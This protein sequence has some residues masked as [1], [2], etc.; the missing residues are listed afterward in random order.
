MVRV[1]TANSRVQGIAAAVKGM[2]CRHKVTRADF[3]GSDC[4]PLHHMA[5]RAAVG[6]IGLGTMGGP[7]A[8]TLLRAGYPLVVYDLDG[9]ATRRLASAGARP[10]ANVAEVARG[11]RTVILMLPSSPEVRQVMEGSEGLLATLK[12]GSL[13]VDMSTIDPL[14]TRQLA[15]AAAERGI[16]MLDAPVSGGPPAAEKGSLTIMVGGEEG[17]FKVARPLFEELGSKVVRCGS[18]GMG[19]TVKLVNQLMAGINMVGVAEALNLGVRCGVDPRV[20][21]EV[22]H[23]ATGDSRVLATRPPY[24]GLVARAPVEE[25]Y[26]GGFRTDLLRKDLRLALDAARELGVALPVTERAL[27]LYDAASTL[28]FGQ[29]DYSAVGE[30]F[31]TVPSEAGPE[32]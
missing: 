16:R 17:D 23:A 6:L 20:L 8:A 21:F 18:H 30:V 29:A 7:M 13:V 2:S 32:S 15:K 1:P 12:P 5:R 10:V 4:L 31:K 11:A 26:H 22:I 9:A 24:R 3:V 28:G 27:E 25:D 19:Q 14:T